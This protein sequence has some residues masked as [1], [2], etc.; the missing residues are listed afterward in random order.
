MWNLERP[1]AQS[2]VINTV[3]P[4]K[5]L[6]E[7]KKTQSRSVRKDEDRY[8]FGDDTGTKCRYPS[9]PQDMAILDTPAQC[10]VP[11]ESMSM[12]DTSLEDFFTSL[13]ARIRGSE[14]QNSFV[15]YDYPIMN[16]KNK[17]Y[18]SLESHI[19]DH[20]PIVPMQL[21]V[22]GSYHAKDFSK[23]TKKGGTYFY[24]DFM[25]ALADH[26]RIKI[27]RIGDIKLGEN[28]YTRGRGAYPDGT[29]YLKFTVYFEKE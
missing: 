29:Y 11:E 9:Y 7:A 5:A 10:I 27:K 3:V 23:E 13:Y 21:S 1:P 15:D 22:C 16:T 24:S 26:P 14:I 18:H 17:L 19:K 4:I 20:P 25:K 28:H 6:A 2:T 8:I 12:L